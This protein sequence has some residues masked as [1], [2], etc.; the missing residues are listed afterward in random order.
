MPAEH[1]SRVIHFDK[2]LRLRVSQR[3]DLLLTDHASFTDLSLLWLQN[4]GGSSRLPRDE[5][6]RSSRRS[7]SPSKPRREACRRFNAGTCPNSQSSCDYAHV[8]SKCR[9]TGHVVSACGK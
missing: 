9:A 3:R 1:H 2:A 4:G 5:T 7:T 6:P 8:C